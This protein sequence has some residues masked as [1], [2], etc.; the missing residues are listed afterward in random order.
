[1][2]TYI[3]R[4]TLDDSDIIALGAAIDRYIDTCKA[5][6]ADGPKAPYWAHLTS[7]EGIKARLYG[8]STMTSTSSPCWP[9]LPDIDS[10][11]LKKDD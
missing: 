3:H 10:M 7:L 6:L 5:E 11:M 9:S 1:M 4:L 8:D 2:T